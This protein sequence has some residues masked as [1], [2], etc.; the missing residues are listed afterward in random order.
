M[1]E[2]INLVSVIIPT[3]NKAFY[4]NLTLAAYTIQTYKDFEIII[5]DDG[6]IDN[7]PQIV[8]KYSLQLNIKYIYQ[9]NQGIARARNVAL[10][11]AKGD[12]I[13]HVDDDRIPNSVFIQ[14]HVEILKKGTK[15]VSI[16]K[17]GRVITKFK[18]DLQ[19][20]FKDGISFFNKFPELTKLSEKDLVTDQDI[21]YNVQK[22]LSLY[23]ISFQNDSL[24]L[25][26]VKEYGNDFSQFKIAW[27]KAYT[28][29]LA[30]NRYCLEKEIFFDENFKGYGCEDID[31]SYNLYLQGYD[32]VFNDDAINYH[33][34]HNR[35]ATE[36]RNHF[37]NIDYF[38]S[39]YPHLEIELV[40]IDWL[41]KISLADVNSFFKVLLSLGSKA[42]PLIENYQERRNIF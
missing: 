38:T 30:Y 2:S 41:G 7:T 6:S 11:R 32:Y 1:I 29:N 20:A 14:K 16:G 40:K 24:L 5:V 27:S 19:F 37:I 35:G 25:D 42:I 23:F 26:M 18:S 13:I 34:E 33:Q 39:K 9:Q 36:I 31:F 17:A 15:I 12:I 21:I 4:L 22:V 3:Y 28:G 8:K 10:A